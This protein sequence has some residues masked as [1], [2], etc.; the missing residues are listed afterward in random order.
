MAH[1]YIEPDDL[2]EYDYHPRNDCYTTFDSSRLTCMECL[3]SVPSHTIKDHHSAQI[4]LVECDC[5]TTSKFH[6]ESSHH[7][8]V[9]RIPT[10]KRWFC[11]AHSCDCGDCTHDYRIH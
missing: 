4:N 6:Y 9:C 3:P 10:V 11:S 7:C 5:G 1:V 2:S 8:L